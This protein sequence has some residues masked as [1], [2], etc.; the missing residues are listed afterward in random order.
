MVQMINTGLVLCVSP[1]CNKRCNMRDMYIMIGTGMLIA[2]VCSALTMGVMAMV[3]L[4]I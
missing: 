3:T 4:I 2:F 1:I